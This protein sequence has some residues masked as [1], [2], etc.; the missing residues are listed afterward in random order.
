MEFRRVLFRSLG[1]AKPKVFISD[2]YLENAEPDE[3]EAI[4]A[5]EAGHLKQKHILKRL[6]YIV[7][8]MYGVLIIGNLLDWYKNY[9][10]NEINLY[11]GLVILLA[12]VILYF[13][14]D[15]KSVV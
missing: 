5:H 1:L 3:I 10:G 13:F 9:T 2:Y 12:P 6:L 11:L 14:V 4:V 15:R 8:G 7:A